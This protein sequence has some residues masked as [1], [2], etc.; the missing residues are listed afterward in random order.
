MSSENSVKKRKVSHTEMKLRI[1]FFVF[2]L[3]FAGGLTAAYIVLHGRKIEY[4]IMFETIALCIVFSILLFY[5]VLTPMRDR[6]QKRCCSERVT[7]RIKS[8]ET[9]YTYESDPETRTSRTEYRTFLPTY[10]YIF[11]GREYI[12]QAVFS[13]DL[14]PSIGETHE[15]LI[16]PKHPEEIYESGGEKGLVRITMA[17][18][19]SVCFLLGSWIFNN[20]FC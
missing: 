3:L 13:V 2:S 4:Y 19:F 17:L 5:A 16:N 7:A 6:L 15:L 10:H 8:F 12:T 14:K 11:N 9:I 20:V 1:V 18:C